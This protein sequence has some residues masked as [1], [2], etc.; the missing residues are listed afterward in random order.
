MKPY[1]T[2]ESTQSIS[3]SVVAL[4]LNQKYML[5]LESIPSVIYVCE[6]TCVPS[7]LGVIYYLKWSLF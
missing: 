2:P 7:L 1:L 5:L 3:L 4:H 6:S